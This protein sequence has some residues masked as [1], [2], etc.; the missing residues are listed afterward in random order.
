MPPIFS[1]YHKDESI[2]GFDG[3]ARTV[4]LFLF[5]S[6]RAEFVHIRCRV[7][8]WRHLTLSIRSIRLTSISLLICRSAV[9]II[10]TIAAVFSNLYTHSQ[11]SRPVTHTA[12]PW[13]TMQQT[14]DRSNE[15]RASTPILLPLVSTRMDSNAPHQSNSLSK[16]RV[17]SGDPG[18]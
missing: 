4:R 6:R 14:A 13:H 5:Q 3:D 9:V 15:M 11:Q 12:S 2:V 7:A 17:V 10:F 18:Q 16:W 8:Y 1:P